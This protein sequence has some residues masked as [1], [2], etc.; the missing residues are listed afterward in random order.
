M[1]WFNLG[2]LQIL[3]MD[4]RNDIFPLV[5]SY[6]SFERSFQAQYFVLAYYSSIVNTLDVTAPLKHIIETCFTVNVPHL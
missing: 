4:L 1:W 5:M 6:T 2:V 3:N